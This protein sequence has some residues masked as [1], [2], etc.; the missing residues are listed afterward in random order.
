MYLDRAAINT[1]HDE[2]G[3]KVNFRLLHRSNFKAMYDSLPNWQERWKF[4]R[5]LVRHANENDIAATANEGTLITVRSGVRLYDHVF[6]HGYAGGPLSPDWEQK[7]EAGP[8]LRQW[9][10]SIVGGR[11]DANAGH[12]D[13]DMMSP[14]P[15]WA[16]HAD[17]PNASD[18][19]GMR[20]CEMDPDN[21]Q[22][23]IF[24]MRGYRS[25]LQDSPL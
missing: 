11:K 7:H 14:L 2:E 18:R 9:I 21:D 12:E 19:C 10:M 6:A 15:G 22:L 20:A 25:K 17:L 3:P 23:A 4:Q 5:A 1:H 24:E 8:T 16:N 13:R